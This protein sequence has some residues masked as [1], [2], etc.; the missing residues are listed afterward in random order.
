MKDSYGWYAELG[1][2]LKF[3]SSLKPEVL[4]IGI[5]KIGDA[6]PKIILID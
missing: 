4:S 3:L 5:K 6:Y 2:V 1:G